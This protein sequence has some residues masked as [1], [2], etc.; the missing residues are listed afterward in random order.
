M[1]QLPYIINLAGTGLVPTHSMNPHV[2]LSH[3]EIVDDVARCLELGV[4]IVHL[5]AR[6]KEG[7]HSA[8]PERYGRLIEAIRMLPGGREVILCVS[9]SGRQDASFESRARVLEL[10]GL[11]KPDMA[12]LTLSS[13]N[14]IQQASINQPQTIR[15][16]AQRMLEQGIR[17]ELEIF[18][19]GMANFLQV[20][21]REG[22]V[23]GPFYANLLLGNIAGAQVDEL[24]LAVMRSLLPDGAVCSVAGIGRQQLRANMMG[25]LSADGVRVG[26]E[27]NLWMDAGRT[28]LADNPKLIQRI[29]RIAAELERPLADC[30][31]V[32]QRL[33][34]AGLS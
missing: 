32:R 29:K 24:Q 11:M 9:T 22:L 3:D 1:S 34:L 23:V 12:S 2:P 5:H 33:G 21:I 14:F 31:A 16:L 26:L 7:H 15:R 18:D 30:S 25:L 28:E 17:P 6:D 20:L 8:D 27:D 19:L 13:L 4:Q 10:D